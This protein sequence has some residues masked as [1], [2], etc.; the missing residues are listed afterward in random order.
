MGSSTSISYSSNSSLKNSSTVSFSDFA[1]SG[2]K[3]KRIVAPEVREP[4]RDDVDVCEGG[5]EEEGGGGFEGGA[6]AEL[7]EEVDVL[8]ANS[9]R[10]QWPKWRDS[11]EDSS[12]LLR[13]ILMSMKRL[14]SKVAPSFVDL[15]CWT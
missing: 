6:P 15:W 7:E 2:S 10:G 3:T 12:S 13:W 9:Q 4:V 8:T 1:A 11:E 5:T 14:M